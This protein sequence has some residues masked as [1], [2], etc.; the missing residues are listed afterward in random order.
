ME[1]DFTTHPEVLARLTFDSAGRPVALVAGKRREHEH[2]M[3]L[4][5][6]WL[7]AMKALIEGESVDPNG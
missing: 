3:Q 1:V 5:M 2:D 7:R 6:A 4:L